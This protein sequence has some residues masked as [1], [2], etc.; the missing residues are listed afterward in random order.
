MYPVSQS[1]QYDR[2]ATMFSPDGRLY[3][4]EYASKIV[5]QGTIGVALKYKDG[6]LFGAEKKVPSRLLLPDSIEKMFVVDKHIAVVSA[7]LVG[8]ARRLVGIARGK[9]QENQ[10]YYEESIQLETLVKDIS[11]IMQLFTQYG[12]MRPFGISFIVGGVDNS[13]KRLFETEPSGALAEYQAIAIGKGK[14]KAMEILEKEY[15]EDISL[16]D[17][18]KLLLKAIEGSLGEKEKLD[19]KRVEFAFIDSKRVFTRI[20]NDKLKSYLGTS[21]K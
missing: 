12:G 1:S 18:M 15:K 8:D 16:E 14:A 10:M 2:V 5:S 4:V 19:L 13:G 17:G 20:P 7:G 9:A 11:N 6:V 21:A 3:Q